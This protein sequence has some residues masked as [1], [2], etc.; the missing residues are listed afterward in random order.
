MR[1]KSALVITCVVA[2]FLSACQ[3]NYITLEYTNAK[4][5]VSQLEN[6]SFR[7][8]KA[9]HPDS[10]LNNWDST[11]Y[12][13]FEPK[14]PGR[15]RWSGPDELVFSP[16]QPL[17]PATTYKVKYNDDLFAYS[18]YDDVKGDAPSF[19]T[20]PLRLNDAQLTWITN[21]NNTA[22]PQLTL[23]F[24]YPLKAQDVQEKLAVEV[25][26]AKADYTLTKAGI[27]SELGVRITSLKP[28]DKTYE[29]RIVLAAGLKPEKGGN[30]TK[31][32]VSQSLTIPSPYVLSVSKLEAEHTGTEGLIRLY[33][34]QQLS[35]ENIG[36][37]ISFQPALPFVV[38]YT[39]FGAILRSEK[40]NAENSYSLNIKK[41]L[42]GRLGGTLK[43]DYYGAVGFGEME[44]GIK[45]TNSKAVYLSKRGA[46]NIEVQVTNTPRLKVIISKIYEN[47][48]LQALS[49]GYE[50]RE[51]ENQP[52]YASY[53][54]GNSGVEYSSYMDAMA[55]DVIQ[56]VAG[57]RG[58]IQ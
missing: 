1:I 9:L 25:D 12:L 8:N 39:D 17:L 53:D 6:L 37:Y 46:G 35:P 11:A 3:R 56:P 38:E 31:E 34:S 23:R 32:A 18:K 43:E 55:G 48:L 27:T 15:F 21:G 51:D 49:S 10:L 29:A 13:S 45:F 50:P 52:Q 16:S 58:Y 19:S 20:A 57:N 47:N 36:N 30:G 4:G 14:I 28:Q 33:A 40:F 7:F 2:I 54:E 44:S 22:M 5:E 26:G 42:H 24:N 41:G